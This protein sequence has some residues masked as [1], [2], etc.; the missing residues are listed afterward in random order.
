MTN[1]YRAFEI[2]NES[3][4]YDRLEY[5]VVGDLLKDVYLQSR[6]SLEIQERGGARARLDKV[7]I[8][9]IQSVEG[10]SDGALSIQA[11]W[12]ASGSVNHF[13]HTHYRNNAYEGTVVI[14]PVEGN[15]KIREIRITDESSFL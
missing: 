11:A 12:I 9:G 5:S 2:R 4:L 13:G 6:Q 15:W 7:E 3:K 8:T 10:S 14:V 1:V